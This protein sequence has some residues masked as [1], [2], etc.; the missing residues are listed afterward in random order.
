M[1]PSRA[2]WAR[3]IEMKKKGLILALDLPS[4]R[5]AK[6]IVRR[7]GSAVDFYK[8][9]PSLLFQDPGFIAW[10][11]RARKKIFLDCKWYDIP[12]QVARSIKEAGR[13]G[14]DACTV[15]ASAGRAVLEAA[16][17]VSPR[18]RIWGVTVLTSLTTKE[19]NEAGVKGTA[20]AQVQRLAGLASSVKLDGL[21]CSPQ[22]LPLLQKFHNK[23]D[24]VTPGIQWGGHAGKDQRRL[25]TPDFAWNAGARYIVVGRAI[26]EAQDPARTAR[27][28]M[29]SLKK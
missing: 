6:N 1:K 13:L 7:L 9:A 11:K 17:S 24:L 10:L 14:V 15:H 3:V 29:D 5:Q 16:V 19:I 18:P 25:A 21:V 4:P 26:L 28:I 23:L 8:V 22:E 20:P 12:S 2:P 27:D